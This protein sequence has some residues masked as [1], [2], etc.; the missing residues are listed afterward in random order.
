MGKDNGKYEIEHSLTYTTFTPPSGEIDYLRDKGELQK[1]NYQ[2]KWDYSGKVDST[3]SVLGFMPLYLSEDHWKVAKQLAKPCLG[4]TATGE[5]LGYMFSQ[6][7]TIPFMLLSSTIRTCK[8]LEY[9]LEEQMK[10]VSKM[11]NIEEL[12]HLETAL[13]LR[14]KRI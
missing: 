13:N 7:Q 1:Y 8:E 4:F 6:Y 12:K 14:K 5:P 9:E 10:Q 3:P 2:E 11:K